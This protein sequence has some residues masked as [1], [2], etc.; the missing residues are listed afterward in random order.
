M[1]G[2]VNVTM[3]GHVNVTMHGH[4]NVKLSWFSLKQKKFEMTDV[5]M[6]SNVITL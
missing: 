6:L 2:H 3:H 4:V 1:H 5:N